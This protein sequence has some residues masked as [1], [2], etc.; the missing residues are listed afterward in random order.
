MAWVI[1]LIRVGEIEKKSLETFYGENS[2]Y[3]G[4][5]KR[6]S[7]KSITWSTGSLGHGLSVTCGKALA[8]RNKKYFCIL[9]DG[10]MNEGSA[11]EALMFLS[12]HQLSNIL[13][14]IDN[15]KQESLDLTEKILSIECLEKKNRGYEN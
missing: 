10:E 4:H 9:G 11:W 8:N 2:N 5:P 15:N 14:L 13:V 3:G 1:T 12:Q 7:S 6:G